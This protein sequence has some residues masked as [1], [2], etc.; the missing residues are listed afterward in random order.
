MPKIIPNT[1]SQEPNLRKDAFTLAETLIAMAIIGIVAVMTIPAL[2]VSKEKTENMTRLKKAYASFNQALTKLTDDYGC[3]GNLE[4][5]GLIKEDGGIAFGNEIIKRLKLSKNCGINTANHCFSTSINYA[6]NGSSGTGTSYDSNYRFITLDGIAFRIESYE[7]WS[8]S[9]VN[10]LDKMGG[11]VY[12][13]VNGP[14][15]GPNYFG[16]DVFFFYLTSGR[17]SFIYPVGGPADPSQPWSKVD[18]STNCNSVSPLATNCTGRIM[19]E[20]WTI[21]YY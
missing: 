2:L 6:Y 17:S 15:S 9:L 21:N 8:N 19:Q 12:I 7:N 14:N 4:C 3:A 5:T 10:N 11:V 1:K 18:T 13:D 16:R 20:S